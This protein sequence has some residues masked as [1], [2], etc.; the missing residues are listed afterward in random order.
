ML[1]RVIL[2]HFCWAEILDSWKSEISLNCSISWIKKKEKKQKQLWF[3]W[4]QSKLNPSFPASFLPPYFLFLF[5]KHTHYSRLFI[6]SQ[7]NAPPALSFK[8]SHTFFLLLTVPIHAFI[9]I[10]SVLCFITLT[11]LSLYI[12]Q[13][14]S[15]V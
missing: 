1:I 15:A 6:S 5:F 11:L 13:H 8:Y 10:A 2:N 12:W 4:I 3:D 9:S 7:F 14:F